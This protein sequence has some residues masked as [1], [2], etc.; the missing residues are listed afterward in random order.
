M[1]PPRTAVVHITHDVERV[2]SCPARQLFSEQTKAKYRRKWPAM[3][4]TTV[5]V[6]LEPFHWWDGCPEHHFLLTPESHEELLS[7]FSLALEERKLS[8]RAIC[9]H[10][11]DAD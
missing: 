11:V 2:L 10:D 5:T 9:I 7:L 4:G 6:S 1:T 8:G 3:A